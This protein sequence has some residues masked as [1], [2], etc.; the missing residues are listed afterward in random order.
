MKK[1]NLVVMLAITFIAPGLFAAD[2]G[3]SV[4]RVG[5]GT[6][7]AVTSP[8]EIVQ[9]IKEETADK[10]AAGVVTGSV[11]GGAKATGQAVEGAADITTGVV[12]TILSPITGD[13]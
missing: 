12:D 1:V 6:V 13:K 9:S 5:E 3:S 4:E 8:G 7:K 11:V 2:A 10:G